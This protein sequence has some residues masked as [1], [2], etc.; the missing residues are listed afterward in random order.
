MLTS[1]LRLTTRRYGGAQ[2]GFTLI[3][4][5]IAMAILAIL[6]AVGMPS[7]RT[8]IQNLQIRNAAESVQNGL[9]LARMEALRRNTEVRFQLVSAISADCVLSATGTSWIV[10]RANPAEKCD[11]EPHNVTAPMIIQKRAPTDGSR[12]ATFSATPG[13]AT[14]VSFNGLGRVVTTGVNPITRID[15]DSSNLPAADSREL[16]VTISSGGEVRMCDP[17]PD[18][19]ATDPRKCI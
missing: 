15:F 4:V 7:Y 2:L 13:T 17:N 11:V 3:E 1:Q 6:L 9:Q 10:S 19:L 14:T 12:S 5:A 18:L 16:R 8:W